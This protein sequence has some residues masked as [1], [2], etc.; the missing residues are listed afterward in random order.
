MGPELVDLMAGGVDHQ[1]TILVI[2]DDD[3]EAQNRVTQS[4][5]PADEKGPIAKVTFEQ[6]KRTRRT[7]R[8]REFMVRK[9]AEVLRGA[10]AKKVYRIGWA[11]LILHVQSS[12]RLVNRHRTR[13]STPTPRPV[14]SSGWSSRTTPL[15]RTRSAG[16]T[17]R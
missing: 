3:V 9:A 1:L 15:R 4:V 7:L 11:P 13:H 2:T 10:G 14:R 5:L 8:N 17:P 12:M 16:Q 6:R